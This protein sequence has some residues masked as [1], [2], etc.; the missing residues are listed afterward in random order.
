[1]SDVA[2]PEGWQ[3][4][5]LGDVV[6]FIN[7]DRGKTYPSQSDFV[8]SGIPFIS[9]VALN[10][11][12]I[13]IDKL[14]YISQSA[15]DKINNGKVMRNDLLFCLR[16]SLGKVGLVSG[17]A[18]GA[19]ASSL[20]IIRTK[21]DVL[22]R[23]IYFLLSGQTGQSIAKEL[24]NGSVQ[25]NLSVRELRQVSILLPPLHEQKAIAHI[26]GSLD[27]KIDQLRKTN[28]VLEDMASALFKSWFVDFDPVTAKQENRPTGLPKDLDDLFP[29][30]FEDSAL[31]PIPKGWRVGCV[32]D[33]CNVVM[34]QSPPG[35]TYNSNADGIPFY[36]GSTD[37]EAFFPKVRIYCTQPTRMASKGDVLLSVRAPVGT[38]NFASTDC[39]IGRGV[40]SVI[41]RDGLRSFTYQLLKHLASDFE[42][43]NAEGTVFGSINKATLASIPVIN[44]PEGISYQY[45]S[46]YGSFEPSVRVNT[47]LIRTLNNLRDTLLPKLISGDLRVPEAEQMVAELGL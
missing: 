25:G 7:G 18:T 24:D 36:Q 28:T 26:L 4:V 41:H 19:I 42:T 33:V 1:M 5:R 40:A 15:F 35:S 31:G 2:I 32:G 27:D 14:S 34:G 8:E 10:G 44:P 17:I 46:N 11:K 22:F 43:Y 21:P 16:G 37:F 20:V 12:S 13:D 3:Q 47:H 29:D 23:Y 39:C 9:A 30:S 6:N 45:D 38:I